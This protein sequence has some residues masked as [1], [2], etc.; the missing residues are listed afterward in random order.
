MCKSTLRYVAD[1]HTLAKHEETL[2]IAAL[3]AAQAKIVSTMLVCYPNEMTSDEFSVLG[4][5]FESLASNVDE[6]LKAERE[7]F[8]NNAEARP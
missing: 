4:Q 2:R 7:R 5:L 3:S 1:D 6:F 8:D